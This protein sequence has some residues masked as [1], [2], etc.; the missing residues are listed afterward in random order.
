M[1]HSIKYLLNVLSS[2]HFL[3]ITCPEQTRLTPLLII[4]CSFIDPPHS[5]EDSCPFLQHR[6]QEFFLV[7]SLL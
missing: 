7:E 6:K 3:S 4:H 2:V 5:G 1:I